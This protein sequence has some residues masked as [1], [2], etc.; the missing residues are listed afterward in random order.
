VNIFIDFL[1]IALPIPALQKLNLPRKTKQSL[2]FVFAAGGGGCI[3]SIFRLYSIL[4]LASSTNKEYDN[5]TTAIWS[6]AEISV[7]L[8]CACLPA[9]R[10]LFSRQLAKFMK[11]NESSTDSSTETE[12]TSGGLRD[13][14]GALLNS[15]ISTKQEYEGFSRP[16]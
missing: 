4:A 1:L 2:I 6:T 11:A 14:D 7:G 9:L 3:I 16:R 15:K 13:T 12:S 5:A 8:I 10:P